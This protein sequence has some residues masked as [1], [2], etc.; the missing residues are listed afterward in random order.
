MGVD[1]ARD[2][3]ATLLL[4]CQQSLADFG[5][6]AGALKGMAEFVVSRRY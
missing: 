6:Q 5:P 2:Y 3:L 1:D 4:Q